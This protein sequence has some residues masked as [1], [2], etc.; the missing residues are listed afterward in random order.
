M[1]CCPCWEGL[2]AR[3]AHVHLCVRKVP[4]SALIL[5]TGPLGCG[6]AGD[7]SE[8]EAEATIL[9]ALSLGIRYVDTAPWY[10]G[11]LSE[12]RVGKALAA[13]QST[14]KEQ[15][16]LSTKVGRYIIAKSESPA[17]GHRVETGYDFNTDA[18]HS[19]IP[20]WDYRQEGIEECL[21]QSR[22]RLQRNFIDC[23]RIHDAE[24]QERWE[25]ACSADGAVSTLVS[26]RSRGEI[27][28]VSLGYNSVEYL[29]KT[30]QAFPV[31]TFDNIMVART[32]NLLDQTAYPLLLECQRRGIKVHMAAIFCAGL[33]WGQNH[34]M[35]SSTVPPA[36]AEKAKQWEDLC[37]SFSLSL[38][39]V[40]M[41]FAYLPKCVERIAVGCSS[42]EQVRSNVKL[43]DVEVPVELWQQAKARGLLPGYVTFESMP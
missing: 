9:K 25:E 14:T 26:L 27:G 32:W 15:I 30:I 41:A 5:G 19:N 4:A 35:Y 23:L 29:M 20:V 24:T 34:F 37:K 7:V 42:A 8:G 38:P 43:C 31:G 12:Q 17:Y 3:K 36:I 13:A 16:G 18:Y 11:G 2:T 33:L 1:D 6:W 10:G 21:R 39:A 22:S 40:A 28:Q